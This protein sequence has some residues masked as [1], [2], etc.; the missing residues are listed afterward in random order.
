[1]TCKEGGAIYIFLN[2]L[3]SFVNL[4]IR[5]MLFQFF[6]F[7]GYDKLQSWD[8]TLKLFE[9][10]YAISFLSPQ[11]AAVMGTGAE[12]IFACLILMGLLTRIS[13]WGLFLLNLFVMVYAQHL[14][15]EM[16]QVDMFVHYFWAIFCMVILCYGPGMI[17]LDALF[18]WLRGRKKKSV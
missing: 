8:T 18:C 1:M 11:M 12:I 2:K 3:G 9:N 16:G 14:H 13:A 17:S 10:E 6:F 7:S 4:L 5:V 15:T